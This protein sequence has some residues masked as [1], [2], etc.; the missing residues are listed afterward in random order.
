MALSCRIINKKFTNC[1]GGAIGARGSLLHEVS[2]FATCCRTT[3]NCQRAR[4]H[5]FVEMFRSTTR[6][7]KLEHASNILVDRVLP[8][9]F[10][11]CTHH[12]RQMK[13]SAWVVFQKFR[14]E[15]V[16]SEISLHHSTALY[17]GF[18]DV[19]RDNVFYSFFLESLYEEPAQKAGATS[20]N[21]PHL[22]LSA[23]F[24]T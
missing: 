11:S 14:Q 22:F 15:L 1:L 7:Q 12:R 3:E 21:Y 5:N 24:S 17:F 10:S 6:L 8:I 23:S 2:N 18:S 9:S 19:H 4:K 16:V 13:N 20:H